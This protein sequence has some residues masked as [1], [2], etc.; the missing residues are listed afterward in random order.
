MVVELGAIQELSML[1]RLRHRALGGSLASGL[2]GPQRTG[3]H[4]SSGLRLWV[5]RRKVWRSRRFSGP[6][7]GCLYNESVELV[8]DS[9]ALLS[10]TRIG[11]FGKMQFPR[12]PP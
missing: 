7:L 3:P 6:Q 12:A 10:I 9:L 8:R 1:C 11:R 2:D 5:D 4:S